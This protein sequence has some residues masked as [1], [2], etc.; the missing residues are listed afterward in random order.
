MLIPFSLPFLLELNKNIKTMT[1]FKCETLI[2]LKEHSLDPKIKKYLLTKNNV[3]ET[4]L[5]FKFWQ[6]TYEGCLWLRALARGDAHWNKGGGRRLETG[7]ER[8]A[9]RARAVARQPGS[10]GA[11]PALAEAAVPAPS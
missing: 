3:C 11:L 1:F 6:Y 5:H 9:A 4:D 2:N 7:G 8:R 10:R